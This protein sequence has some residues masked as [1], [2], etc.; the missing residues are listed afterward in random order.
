MSQSRSGG[1]NG[2]QNQDKESID[3]DHVQTSCQNGRPNNNASLDNAKPDGS[4]GFEKW[5]TDNELNVQ[6]IA[7]PPLINIQVPSLDVSH[8]GQT[9]AYLKR[10][11]LIG[12]SEERHTVLGQLPPPYQD[13]PL[14]GTER[15]QYLPQGGT[16]TVPIHVQ[17]Q[18]VSDYP[19]TNSQ[20]SQIR[21]QYE[22]RSQIYPPQSQFS[23]IGGYVTRDV[24]F[25]EGNLYGSTGSNPQSSGFS[26]QGQYVTIQQ[27]PIPSQSTSPQP[28]Y[29]AGVVLPPGQTYAQY[30]YS[31]YPQTVINSAP[32]N[33]HATIYS[34]QP[35]GQ[36]SPNTQRFS[37]EMTQYQSQPIIQPISQNINHG[38]SMPGTERVCRG[39]K[40]MVPPRINSKITHESGLGK[41]VCSDSNKQ[42]TS[43]SVA[44]LGTDTSHTNMDGTEKRY[45]TQIDHNPRTRQDGLYVDTNTNSIASKDKAE[46]LQPDSDIYVLRTEHD[47]LHPLNI[48]GTLK[49]RN[50]V[51]F[52][53]ANDKNQEIATERNVTSAT[54]TKRLDGNQSFSNDQKLPDLALRTSPMVFDMRQDNRKTLNNFSSSVSPNQRLNK[55]QESRR[56]DY[57]EEQRRSPMIFDGKRFDEVRRSPMPFVSSR[58]SSTDRSKHNSSPFINQNFEKTRQELAMWAEQKQRQEFEKIGTPGQ[59]FITSPRS[60]NH[61]EERRLQSTEERKEARLSQSA[62]QPIS[63]INQ[64]TIM[65]QRRH[66]RHVSAD[67]TKHVEFS[68]KE[69]DEQSLHGSVINLGSNIGPSSQRASPN[70]CS[71]YPT[72]SEAKLNSKQSLTVITDFNDKPVEPSDHIIHSHRKS[73]NITPSLMTHSKSQSENISHDANSLIE[74][75]KEQQIQNQQCLDILSEKLT[76]CER[77]QS[78]LQAKLQCLQNQNQILDKVA[79][80]QQN[81]LQARYKSQVSPKDNHQFLNNSE[82]DKMISHCPQHQSLL[83]TVLPQTSSEKL[84][85]RLQVLG[86]GIPNIS[87][88]PLSVLPPVDRSEVTRSPFPHYHRSQFATDNLDN[89]MNVTA[90]TSSVGLNFTGTL[91]KI[92]PEKPPR[93]SLIIHSPESEVRFLSFDNI[94]SVFFTFNLLF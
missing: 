30:S 29:Y 7:P 49:R 17:P 84:S 21:S 41:T 40:P 79:A 66:L 1:L 47:K 91:K 52:S 45:V 2:A 18:F 71:Q 82:P 57:F 34:P 74:K 33:S 80:Y 86:N 16:Q 78:D 77:Q 20:Y 10:Q 35:F 22:M 46:L 15:V 5:S 59:L 55:C 14:P 28:P 93:T 3:N 87:Q 38:I 31:Q 48:G 12:Q 6:V 60:R 27:T 85:P 58:D 73:H 26:N 89:V 54:D 88:L 94:L 56:S 92:P 90:H 37:Q 43:N 65:E 67:L 50:D 39:P 70:I 81:D 75:T 72:T 76:E 64:N 32:Y 36:Q 25:R 8:D 24:T 11:S 9:G 4:V 69:F 62:F 42:N 51:T 53:I 63:N 44:G 23:D 61:S 19:S 13:K 68:K 83:T